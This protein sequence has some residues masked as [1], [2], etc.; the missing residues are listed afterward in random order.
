MGPS[1]TLK[2]S[3]HVV[4]AEGE[5]YMMDRPFRT[6]SDAIKFGTGLI[7]REEARVVLVYRLTTLTH[8]L[9]YRPT[10]YVHIERI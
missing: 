3:L 9:I 6:R 5:P 8:I 2:F 7:H 4:P 1:E 10:V